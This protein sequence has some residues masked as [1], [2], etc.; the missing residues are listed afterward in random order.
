MMRESIYNLAF[1]ANLKD[2][3]LEENNVPQISIPNKMTSNEINL[4]AF[5]CAFCQLLCSALILKGFYNKQNKSEEDK[6]LIKT[7]AQ[8]LLDEA[9]S[10]DLA[11]KAVIV[12]KF[13]CAVLFHMKFEPE[14]R[15]GL[16]MMKYAA[17]H[18]QFFEYP[19]L[20]FLMGFLNMTTIYLV[21][22]VNL[23]NLSNTTQGTYTLITSFIALGIIGEFDDYFVEIY[24]N[25]RVSHLVCDFNLVVENVKQSKRID[26]EVEEYKL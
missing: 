7:E 10:R 13:I 20:S 6:Q 23:W 16:S 3:K 19:W 17:I 22:F 9:A 4:A 26:P 25:S 12:I 11:N 24:K 1:V 18:S 15:N 2:S 21:E 14:I 5:F 8:V